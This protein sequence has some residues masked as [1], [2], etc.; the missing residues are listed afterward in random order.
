MSITPWSWAL[1]VLI[2]ADRMAIGGAVQGQSLNVKSFSNS[3]TI[4][5]GPANA[6]VGDVLL[7]SGGN[8]P[9]V[10]GGGTYIANGA[11]PAELVGLNVLDT[12]DAAGTPLFRQMIAVTD[13]QDDARIRYVWLNRQSNRVEPKVAW[14]HRE[15]D[16]V[17]GVGYHAPRSTADDAQIGRAHV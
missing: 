3:G 4:D 7:I 14:L 17:V 10:S 16:Y 1:R 5:M 11:A 9:G 8:T 12:V 15:G 13:K 2:I 6:A